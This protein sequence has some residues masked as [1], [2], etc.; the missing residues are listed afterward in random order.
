MPQGL[1]KINK[2]QGVY[3][4]ESKKNRYKGQPDR[5]YYITY[6]NTAKKFVREK[7]GWSSEGYNAALAATVRSDRVRD[8]R[9]GEALPGKKK[10]ELT[11]S[12]A[13]KIYDAWLETGKSHTYDDRNRY[14]NHI[15]PK[16]ASKALSQIKTEDLENF[17]TYLLTQKKLSPAT[18]KHILVIIRQVYNKMITWGHYDGISPIKGLVMPKINNKRVR[19]LTKNEADIL[20][21]TIKGKSE[22]VFEI[23]LISLHT[24]MRA[25]EVLSLLWGHLDFGR[26]IIHVA[27]PK[28]GKP[29]DVFMTE[30][31]NEMLESKRKGEPAELVFKA[32]HGGKIPIMSKTFLNSV[33][34][35]KFNEGIADRR[36]QVSFHTLRHTFASWLA[37]SGTPILVIKE[38]LGH[39]TLA[40]TERYA[41]LIPD[42]KRASVQR[43]ESTYLS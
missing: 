17:K 22:Q 10:P 30:R 19:F 27:D 41:H 31:V 21:N 34:E 9:H 4:L 7:V 43:I 18:T 6:R 35:L 38:L 3:Y 23:S 2:F 26:G 28:G 1:I 33:K 12:E 40:M 16:F 29:R 25:D 20:L 13:W 32:R 24:G 37:I 5:C 15:R 14:K 11:F 42:Q 8:V 39:A 36:Q